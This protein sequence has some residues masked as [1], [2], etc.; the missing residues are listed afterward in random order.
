MRLFNNLWLKLISVLIAIAL[1]YVMT[2]MK[3]DHTGEENVHVPVKV[4]NVP[5]TLVIM[6][7]LPDRIQMRLRGN[8]DL[9]QEILDSIRE[10]TVDLKDSQAGL[11]VIPIQ[12]AR[13]GIPETIDITSILPANLEIK[14]ESRL[15]VLLP[16][17]PQINTHPPRGYRWEST[18]NPNM[19]IVV[20]PESVVSKLN[21][22]MTIPIEIDPDTQTTSMSALLT[23]PHSLVRILMPSAVTVDIAAVPTQK[24]P[25]RPGNTS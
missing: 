6:G 21:T 24:R 9:L 1:W 20:G 16:V 19:A 11:K 17:T 2:P 25:S 3:S 18:T 22:V 10:Y 4:I 23:P 15:Q 12:P 13:L 7:E 5:P 14:L 8:K